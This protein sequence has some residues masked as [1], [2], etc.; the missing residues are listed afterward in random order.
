M[1]KKLFSLIVYWL[2]AQNGFAQDAFSV[3]VFNH[4][5]SL[6][7]GTW[8]GAIH[9]GF[10]LAMITHTKAR[11]KSERSIHW[12]ASY[13][14]HRLVHHSFLLFG[15]Y[16]WQKKIIGNLGFGLAGGAGYQHTFEDHEIFSLN[17]SG[18]YERSAKAGK[19]HAHI[20]LAAKIQYPLGKRRFE[21]FLQYR[22]RLITP[23]VK[24][25]VPVLPAESYHVGI[26]F[27]LR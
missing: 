1:Q 19:A 17:K 6:P 12:H 22:L 3:S 11:Q 13:Y 25:Y 23:F 21:P 24:T 15:E 20:S 8:A 7:G 9:P 26:S 27:P 2:F 10:D 14:Y 16:N 4:A 18:K 5:A